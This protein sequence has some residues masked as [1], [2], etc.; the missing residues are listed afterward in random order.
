MQTDLGQMRVFN[1]NVRDYT[2]CDRLTFRR[3]EDPFENEIVTNAQYIPTNSQWRNHF[4][5]P[6]LCKDKETWLRDSVPMNDLPVTGGYRGRNIRVLYFEHSLAAGVL[7]ILIVASASSFSLFW[8]IGK[9]DVSGGFG[10]GAYVLAV[11]A[12]L[13][14][15]CFQEGAIGRR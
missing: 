10:V 5:Y 15:F 11:F 6:E 14:T 12:F 4:E 2:Q 3:A 1:D 8:A 13:V 7:V 9:D